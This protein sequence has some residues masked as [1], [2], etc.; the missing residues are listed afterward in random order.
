MPEKVEMSP[1]HAQVLDPGLQVVI[2]GS[3]RE[4]KVRT[5]CVTRKGIVHV[6]RWEEG[7]RPS[8]EQVKSFLLILRHQNWGFRMRVRLPVAQVSNC[9]ADVPE[10]K[11]KERYL[12]KGWDRFLSC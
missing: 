6:L 11:G 10:G 1:T 5:A 8:V 12:C 2:L 7:M 9:G 4:R 3:Q